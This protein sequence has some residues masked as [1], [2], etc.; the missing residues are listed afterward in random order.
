MVRPIDDDTRGIMNPAELL[1]HTSFDRYGPS[2]TVGRFVV[3]YW[4]ITWDLPD[5][6]IHDQHVVPHPV[7]NLSFMPD[8]IV[9]NGVCR[10]RQT[11]RL[12]GTGWVIGVKFR[13]AGFRAFIDAPLSTL[14]DAV[15]PLTEVFGPDAGPLGT[16]VVAGGPGPATCQRIDDFLAQR[17]PSGRHP[18]EATAALVDQIATDR[19]ITRVDQ[20]TELAGESPRRLQRRFADHVGVS[21]KWVIRRYRIYEVAERAASGAEIDW[22]AL[23]ADLGYADQ[24]HLSRD[25]T[26]VFGVSPSRYLE[27]C[28]STVAVP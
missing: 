11:R 27:R 14:T 4:V 6:A 17:C 10:R 2:P 22:A 20:L 12:T 5:G 18:A 28:R 1:R 26:S 24:A 8:E 23:A 25:F 13:P 19:S 15:V 3:W 9:V 7:V 16:A 21:P